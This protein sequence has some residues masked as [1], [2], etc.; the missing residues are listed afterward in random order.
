M[1][2]VLQSSYKFLLT[3]ECHWSFSGR[4]T[5]VVSEWE[6]LRE[7]VC[8]WCCI[9]RPALKRVAWCV[10][11]QAQRRLDRMAVHPR[12]LP[13]ARSAWVLQ[14]RHRVVLRSVGDGDSLGRLRRDQDSTAR[15][16]GHPRRGGRRR[17]NGVEL[18][19]VHGRR[20]R[21][22]DVCHVH[23]ISTRWV[24]V[25]ELLEQRWTCIR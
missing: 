8:C 19:R 10:V 12:Y 15:D 20:G 4:Q 16:E 17:S 14:G 22:Q 7:G 21:V 24:R 1:L 25:S 23:C 11:L 9:Y 6:F 5:N 18:R 2:T 3:M 13:L